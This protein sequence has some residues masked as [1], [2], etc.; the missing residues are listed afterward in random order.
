MILL[1][2]A[3]QHGVLRLTLLGRGHIQLIL[4]LLH[5]A[6]QFLRLCIGSGTLLLGI[7]QADAELFQLITAAQHACAAADTAARHRAA[8]VHHLTVQRHNA[9]SAAVLTSHSDTAV[10]VLH[11]NGAA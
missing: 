8:A 9:E 7:L 2:L 5:L 11:H 6:A 4:C 1:A 10:H 3:L